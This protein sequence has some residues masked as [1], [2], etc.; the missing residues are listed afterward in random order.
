MS[1]NYQTSLPAYKSILPKL[2]EKQQI[3]FD[4]IQ[5]IQNGTNQYVTDKMIGKYL[6]WDLCK[7]TGR[8]G[9]LAKLGR[10]EEA[11]RGKCPYS[12]SNVTYWKVAEQ[13]LTI[14]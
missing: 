4:T 6:N 9:E 2:T 1:Y 7:V 13:Q 12:D 3:V 5:S 14:F 10:I 11:G 8:R